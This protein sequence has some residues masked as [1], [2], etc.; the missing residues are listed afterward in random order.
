MVGWAGGGEG[1]KGHGEGRGGEGGMGEGEGEWA[2][3]GHKLWSSF[4]TSLNV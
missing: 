4:A 1:G 2:M 3:G